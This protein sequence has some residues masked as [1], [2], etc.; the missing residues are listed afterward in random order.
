M[1]IE[2]RSCLQIFLNIIKMDVIQLGRC[3][4]DIIK[5]G[6]CHGIVQVMFNALKLESINLFFSSL[7]MAEHIVI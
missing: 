6:F 2:K 3:S 1:S 7:L 4:C 5:V